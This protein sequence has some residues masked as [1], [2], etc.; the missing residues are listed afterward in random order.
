MMM[1][2]V[3]RSVAMSRTTVHDGLGN[4]WGHLPGFC[5]SD[6]ESEQEQARS[7]AWEERGNCL[8]NA[9]MG[10]FKQQEPLKPITR[11]DS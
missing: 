6:G 1:D 7:R 3:Q 8:K 10:P 9:W 2:S 5:F 4:L 11:A